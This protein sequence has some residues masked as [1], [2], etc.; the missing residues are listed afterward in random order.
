MAKDR[1]KAYSILYKGI[2]D[3]G[4]IKFKHFLKVNI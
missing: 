2:S 4:K 3:H 1:R